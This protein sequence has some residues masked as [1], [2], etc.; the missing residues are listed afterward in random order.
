MNNIFDAISQNESVVGAT[1]VVPMTAGQI[2]N[3]NNKLQSQNRGYN[4]RANRFNKD[5]PF[6]VSIKF[7]DEWTNFGIF[8]DVDVAAC[9][10]TVVSRGYFGAGGKRGEFDRAKVEASAEWATWL[11]NPKNATIIAQANGQL[12]TVQAAK[13]AELVANTSR[14]GHSANND[15]NEKEDILF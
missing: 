7:D 4:V 2:V 10:G 13:A 3:V 1:V 9:V 8:T 12:M 6:Q 14:A 15:N 5:I 11:A